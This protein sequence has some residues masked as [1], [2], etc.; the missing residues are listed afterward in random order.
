MPALTR[1]GRKDATRLRIIKTAQAQFVKDGIIKAKTSDIASAAGLAHGTIFVHF[2]T[3]EI[4]LVEAVK[5]FGRKIT[6]RIHELE[7]MAGNTREIL[8]AHI[9]GLSL[10]ESFYTRLVTEGPLL[11]AQARQELLMIQ[12]AVSYHLNGAV[13]RDI[14]AGR[15]K[16]VPI[17]LV[18]NTWIGLIHYYLVNR[19]MFSGGGPVLER[20]RDELLD[21]FM[22]LI[23][24]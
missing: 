6:E 24:R 14:A 1:S 11:P 8:E 4:L 22:G 15:L 12:S 9:S 23:S 2:P 16:R 21:F 13:Q 5:D 19:D 20:Y 10:F 7:A 17:H 3:R 18:F